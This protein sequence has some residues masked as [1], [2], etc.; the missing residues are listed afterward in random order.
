MQ[1]KRKIIYLVVIIGLFLRFVLV[2]LHP[3]TDKT[4]TSS[5]DLL[6]INLLNGHGLSIMT[7][8]PYTPYIDRVP[9]YPIFMALLYLIFGH[10]FIVIRSVQAILSIFTA[11]FAY[12]IAKKIV[13]ENDR[14]CNLPIVSIVFTLLCPFLIFFVSIIF[15]ETFTAFLITGSILLF[16]Y[17]LENRNSIYYLCS[18]FIISLAVMTRPEVFAFPIIL[19]V[20]LLFNNLR[21]LRIYTSKIVIYLLPFFIM[22]GALIVRN[23]LVF[24]KI[25]LTTAQDGVFLLVGTYPPNRYEKDFPKEIR[26]EYSKFAGLPEKERVNLTIDMRKRAFQ[27][28]LNQPLQYIGYC[29]QRIPILWVSSYT[30]YIGTDDS[31]G[32]LLYSIKKSIKGHSSFFR[33]ACILFLKAILYLVN[34]SYIILGLLGMILLIKKWSITYP[35]YIAIIYFTLIHIPLGAV[36]PRY[37]IKILPVFLIFSSAGA[38][39]LYYW[40]KYHSLKLLYK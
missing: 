20:T 29:F 27:R 34:I 40:L 15:A 12:L 26:E 3:Y 25:I 10:H 33:E 7:E 19:A 21:N 28:I 23:Y 24:D 31:F 22:W 36:S 30:H 17:G 11:F 6:A 5:Y 4:D 13:K 9:F 2:Y 32:D 37:V 1:N 18:G 8:P 14:L 39:Y 35:L 16:L 38:L